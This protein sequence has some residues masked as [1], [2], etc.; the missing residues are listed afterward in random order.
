LSGL[1][2]CASNY[3]DP[4][5][6]IS[7]STDLRQARPL[8]LALA[9]PGDA[10][11]KGQGRPVVMGGMM[12]VVGGN[13]FQRQSFLLLCIA[14]MRPTTGLLPPADAGGDRL[15]GGRLLRPVALRRRFNAVR[16]DKRLDFRGEFGT[17]RLLALLRLL[18][19]GGEAA[20]QPVA[21]I[22]QV[23][24]I[25]FVR[26]GFVEAF[27]VIPQL[28]F[29]DSLGKPFPHDKY[30]SELTELRDELKAGLSAAAHEAGR[31][32]GM[33]VIE[34]AERIK[35]L[36]AA[37]TIE[38]TPQRVQRKQAAAE[39]PITARIRRRQE[40]NP[41]SD[42][43]V[44]HDDERRGVETLPPTAG[45][46]SPTNPLISFRER[47]ALERQHRTRPANHVIALTRP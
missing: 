18:G 10:L 40:A 43:A 36:K 17:P 31:D 1:L 5:L 47:I 32:K 2:A 3:N 20:L 7:G 21:Q 24:E 29:G 14:G 27:A 28:R 6:L 44:E 45:E 35:S 34:L 4:H 26:E 37:N 46:V 16:G 19:R 15:F 30:L 12:V 22:G 9:L 25:G 11:S 38:A 13:T 42:Q 33:R 23:V 41:L 8:V 39:E